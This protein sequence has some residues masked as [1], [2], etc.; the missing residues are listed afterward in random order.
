MGFASSRADSCS[1]SSIASAAERGVRG[2][3]EEGEEEMDSAGEDSGH[4]STALASPHAG[5]AQSGREGVDATSSGRGRSGRGREGRRG[6]EAKGDDEDGALKDVRDD[7]AGDDGNGGRSAC[8][9][10]VEVRRELTGESGELR[11]KERP[12]HPDRG[13]RSS[14]RIKSP[15]RPLS[16]FD[17]LTTQRSILGLR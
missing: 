1:H 5:R 3:D 11:A 6:C 15:S 10:E 12:S 17:S 13:R 8:A 9:G 7:G 4:T 2:D 14:A 16:V